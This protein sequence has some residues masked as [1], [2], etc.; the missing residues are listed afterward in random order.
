MRQVRKIHKDH[1][2]NV[3]YHQPKQRCLVIFQIVVLALAL[4]GIFNLFHSRFPHKFAKNYCTEPVCLETA[5]GILRDINSSVSPCDNFYNFVCGRFKEHHHISLDL[6]EWTGRDKVQEEN[7]LVI[8]DILEGDYDNIGV[9][10]LTEDE[11]HNDRE[12]F[13]KAKMVYD[14]CMGGAPNEEG[15]GKILTVLNFVLEG[16]PLPRPLPDYF[17]GRVESSIVADDRSAKY[18]LGSTL[19]LLANYGINALFKHKLWMDVK[20]ARLWLTQPELGMPALTYY[21]NETMVT[22]YSV[23]ISETFSRI[24][25]DVM[26][27]PDSD[28]KYDRKVWGIISKKIIEFEKRLMEHYLPPQLREDPSLSYNLM[29][30]TSLQRLAPMLDWDDYF[31]HFYSSDSSA[32]VNEDIVVG[33]P[34]YVG[35]LSSI[36]ANTPDPI[37]QAFLLW[38]A[39]IEYEN[40]LPEKHRQPLRKL[41][42]MLSGTKTQ[43]DS[44]RWRACIA[45]VSNLL[46]HIPARFF[47]LRRFGPNGKHA[48]MEMLENIREA[49]TQNLQQLDWLDDMTRTNAVKKAKELM[50]MAGYPTKSPNVMSPGDLQ[51]YHSNFSAKLLDYLDT[52]IEGRRFKFAKFTQLLGKTPDR[53][54]WEMTS[55]R[56]S[57]YYGP[58]L[59]HLAIP[60]GIAQPPYFHVELPSYINYGAIGTV[61]GHEFT[62]GFDNMGRKYDGQ[63]AVRDWWSEEA[64]HN[65]EKKAQCFVDQYSKFTIPAP[66][67]SFVAL[68]SR[69]TLSEDIADNGGRLQ[70]YLAWKNLSKTNR[71]DNLL[72]GL[73]HY[74]PEQLFFISGVRFFCGYST[75]EMLLRQVLTDEHS[76]GEFR[77]NGVVMNSA[78]FA[79]A[80]N[81]PIGTRMNPK[82]KCAIW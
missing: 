17:G 23:A 6:P 34:E 68:D 21:Q 47:A 60:S 20:M 16:F 31:Q 4:L 82:K 61:I 62:H 25:E 3:H 36:V 53:Y 70:S 80:W 59:A 14:V 48:L 30:I 5:A 41:H 57:A 43:S 27:W 28:N 2:K 13:G 1:L 24:A 77:A 29:N 46:W 78:E 76:P 58:S 32:A 10:K 49:F 66:N 15:A 39:I 81:C 7:L 55:Y 71:K 26:I 19:G 65:F 51:R 12:V 35:N 72:P 44:P 56:V 42:N 8:R 75:P 18:R 33:W 22:A 9:G 40:Y 63:G 64:S 11:E 74:T 37:L 38:Q 79:R 69:N 73:D 50:V 45:E 54:V 67:G 52:G